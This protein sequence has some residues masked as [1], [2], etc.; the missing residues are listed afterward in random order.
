[1]TARI[2]RGAVGAAL[3]LT[4]N[5]VVVRPAG[6]AGCAALA[7]LQL[8]DTTITLAGQT[9]GCLAASQVPALRLIYDGPRDPQTHALIY[10]G[11]NRGSESGSVFALP[12][13][14]GASKLPEGAGEPAD[15]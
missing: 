12:F 15:I 9:G 5:W 11:M 13:L 2:A 4:A 7:H 8:P 14:D 10:P 6:A 1:M 3:L